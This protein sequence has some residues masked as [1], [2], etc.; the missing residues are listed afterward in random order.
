MR[1]LLIGGGSSHDFEKFFHAVDSATLKASGRIIP[2]YTSNVEEALTLMANAD[3]I[4]LSANHPSF[5]GG[6]FQKALNVFADSGKGFVILHAGTWYNWPVITGYNKRFLGGGAKGHGF[7]DFQVLN[8]KEAH[9]VME[10]IP[11][12]FTIHDEHYKVELDANAHVDVL[13]MT[14]VEPGSKK[15]Y[16]SVWVVNDPKAKIVGI[17]LGHGTEAHGNPAYQRLLINAVRW[18]AKWPGALLVLND[19]SCS[20]CH[21]LLRGT[22]VE[23]F[24]D[25]QPVGFDGFGTALE[26][27]SNFLRAHP[28]TDELENLQ[29][30]VA[31]ALDRCCIRLPF[32]NKLREELVGQARTDDE[33]S[34]E[35]GADAL[36]DFVRLLAFHQVSLRTGAKHTFAVKVLIMHGENEDAHVG[37]KG[38][39][40]L[41]EVETVPVRQVEIE[42]G[43]IGMMLLEN[44]QCLGN[45]T[46]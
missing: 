34:G 19:P 13:A 26:T 25:A 20:G 4:V 22:D 18:V 12:E 36:D 9:P 1:T 32:G 30:P 29:L 7:G 2:A 11:A 43:K 6:E 17:G 31:E 37:V 15:A 45:V 39:D 5:G 28:L 24:F 46:D 44:L 8:Q 21:E 41:D 27:D 23:F 33:V 3:V 40:L 42:D 14:S 16:P 38:M 10:G 35:H